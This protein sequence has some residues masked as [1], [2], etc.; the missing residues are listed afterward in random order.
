MKKIQNNKKPP[1]IN[2]FKIYN[3]KKEQEDYI[4]KWLGKSY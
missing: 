3:T 1:D 4:K 2:E